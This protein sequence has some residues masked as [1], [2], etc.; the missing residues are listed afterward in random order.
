[1]RPVDLVK[2]LCDANQRG[3][4]AGMLAPLAPHVTWTEMEGFPLGGTYVG[5]DAIRAGVF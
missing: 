5:A 1:M 3:D 2:P 4:T